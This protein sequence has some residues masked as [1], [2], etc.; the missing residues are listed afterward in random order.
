MCHLESAGRFYWSH[1]DPEIVSDIL[2][3][4]ANVLSFA[5]TTYVMPSHELLGP[6]QISLGRMLGD[7]TRFVVLFCL[8]CRPMFQSLVCSCVVL[9]SIWC[10]CD[11][12]GLLQI[13]LGPHHSIHR[14]LLSGTFH[15]RCV[16]VEFCMVFGV[17]VS[18]SATADLPGT[19]ARQHHSLGYALLSGMLELLSGA[20]FV[21]V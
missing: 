7:I 2:F 18:C 11:L 10:V 8:V 14:A 3:A 13:S 20:W 4:I 6:L 9:Y 15:S 17:F 5:R 21:P 1:E 16:P 19:H 12:L